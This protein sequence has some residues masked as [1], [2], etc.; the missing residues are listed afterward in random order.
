V[1]R[2]KVARAREA[3]VRLAAALSLIIAAQLAA[4]GAAAAAGVFAGFSG[5]W[6]GEGSVVF[7][8]GASERIRC[9]AI[10]RTSSG[11]NALQLELRCASASYQFDVDGRISNAGGN[12]SGTWTE[13]QYDVTGRVSGT[14]AEGR[15]RA[16]VDAPSFGASVNM[17]TSGNAL[18]VTIRPSEARVREVSM[19]LRRN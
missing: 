1:Q 4:S 8:N 10:G 7:T 2:F 9:R 19:Q 3:G 17:T 16:V 18:A 13:R 14:A 11:D 15:F 6:G 5:N 12:L